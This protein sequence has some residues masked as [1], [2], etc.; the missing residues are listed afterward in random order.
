MAMDILL[1]EVRH[2]LRSL[3]RAPVFTSVAVLCLTLAIGA[4]TTI[5]SVFHAVMLNPFPFHQSDRVVQVGTVGYEYD[6]GNEPRLSM[7]QSTWEYFRDHQTVFDRAYLA[8]FTSFSVTDVEHPFQL[9]GTVASAGVPSMLGMRAQIGRILGEDDENTDVVLLSHAAW[10][11]KFGSEPHIVGTVINIDGNPHEVVGVLQRDH[12]YFS[13]A[14]MMVPM[15][16]RYNEVDNTTAISINILGRLREGESVEMVNERLLTLSRQAEPV[17]PS[18][19]TSYRYHALSITDLNSLG[20]TDFTMRI[21]LASVLALLLIA[22]ANV[23]NL[24]L[25]RVHKQEQELAIRS[26]LG[27]RRRHIVR[28]LMIENC[29]LGMSGI[30]LGTVT[31]YGLLPV[32]LAQM[33]TMVPNPDRVSLNLP[34]FAFAVAVTAGT[35]VLVGIIPAYRATRLSLAGALREGGNKGMM[36][37]G[38]SVRKVL[39]AGEVAIAF[40]LLVS[41]SLMFRSFYNIQNIDPGYDPANVQTI[42]VNVPTSRTG[43][44]ESVYNFY[45]ELRQ[46]LLALPQVTE[47][48]FATSAPINDR[49]IIARLSVED[50][51]PENPQDVLQPYP[52]LH[53][54]SQ[55]YF[56]ALDVPLINGRLFDARD[57]E[58]SAPTIIVNQSFAEHLWPGEN[59][60]GKRI[61]RYFYHGTDYPWMEIVGVVGDIRGADGVLQNPA[62]ISFYLPMRQAYSPSRSEDM[63]VMIKTRGEPAAALDTI[64]TRVTQFDS[65]TVLATEMTLIQRLQNSTQAQRANMFLLILLAV[66]GLA[67][68]VA[69]I[70]GVI[71]YTT[72]QRLREV[73]LRMALGAR[74]GSIFRM[75]VGSALLL[76]GTGLVVGVLLMISAA[77]AISSQLYEVNAFDPATYAGIVLITL[78]TV[79]FA[80][81]LPAYRA[82]RTDPVLALRED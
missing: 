10:Q 3:L 66:I 45:D 57:R 27:A 48:G 5:Y 14:D 11:E 51:P 20:G 53:S 36:G 74:S 32:L 55:G 79:F 73:G 13:Q 37:G 29:L 58:D 21:L 67:L 8:A 49:T 7:R 25:I 60:I 9:L 24:M 44:P 26:A 70:F 76:G 52:F 17:F 63:R 35:I 65:N 2:A 69:G 30:A 78:L 68:A 80:A 6:A 81:W 50:F 22:I 59:V 82:A 46:E 62:P 34:V 75:V 43:S 18:I 38:A 19:F 31:A 42:V 40:V 61:K 77:A 72:Q 47:V 23:A 56:E 33:G 71:S 39:V 1:K 12:Q 15:H 64:R 28:R 4:V 16:P 41:A 54:I